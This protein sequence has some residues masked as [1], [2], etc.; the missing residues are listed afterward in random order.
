MTRTLEMYAFI[1]EDENGTDTMVKTEVNGE[2]KALFA[3][4]VEDIEAMS[5]L[6]INAAAEH[7]LKIKL[8]KF[9]KVQEID[10]GCFIKNND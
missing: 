5:S 9:E 2:S 10:F 3:Y 6:A 8:A 1:Y 4:Q 7:N